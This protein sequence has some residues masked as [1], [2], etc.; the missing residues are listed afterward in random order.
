MDLKSISSCKDSDKIN[1][2]QKFINSKNIEEFNY[3]YP[4]GHRITLQM[5]W[6]NYIMKDNVENS[7]D[8]NNTV[9]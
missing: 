3:L 9:L 5:R 8:W 4:N 2:G 7:I 6:F 1:K